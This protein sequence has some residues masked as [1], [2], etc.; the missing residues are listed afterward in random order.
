MIV[1][2]DM[3]G[4]LVDLVTPW[5][6]S[7][8]ECCPPSDRPLTVTDV[9]ASYSGIER[10]PCGSHVYE[11]L[12]HD[13]FRS[14]QPIPGALEGVRA[15]EA[16]GHDVVAVTASAKDPQTA[17]A[18]LAWAEEHLGW[19]R[20]RVIVAQ[21]KELV[22]GDVFVDD[23]P[24]NLQAYGVAWPRALRATIAYPYN[25]GADDGVARFDGWQEPER[26]WTGIV[27]AIAARAA[28]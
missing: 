11:H 3:D 15:L 7:A 27:A 2:V 18:K 5:L 16:A 26:A 12:T 4:I 22:R 24:A 28:R 21:R 8:H 6:R 14:L 1:L 13:L 23:A 25:V 10:A 19:S 17:A 9:I 20:H